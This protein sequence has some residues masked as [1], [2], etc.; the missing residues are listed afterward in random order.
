LRLALDHGR[1]VLVEKPISIGVL[2]AAD[3]AAAGKIDRRDGGVLQLRCALEPV[4]LQKF[5]Q[6]TTP[7]IDGCRLRRGTPQSR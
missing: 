4:G 7:G 5:D 3:M 1:H 2:E 6:R